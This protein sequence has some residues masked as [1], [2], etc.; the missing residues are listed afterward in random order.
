MILPAW[1][2]MRIFG[3]ASGADANLSLAVQGCGPK[4]FKNRVTMDPGT[5]SLTQEWLVNNN[6]HNLRILCRLRQCN[7]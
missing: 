5:I 6:F 1:D 3:V 7:L 2:T 4:A